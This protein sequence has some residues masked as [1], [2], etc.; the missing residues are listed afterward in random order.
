MP[1]HDNVRSIKFEWAMKQKAFR[2]RTWG[3]TRRG[4]GRNPQG[5]RAG[6]AHRPRE[7]FARRLPVHVT[8]RMARGV[9]NLRSRR[10]FRVIARSL[11]RGGADRFGVRVVQFS[12]QGNHIHWLVEAPD[13]GALARAMKGLA[14]R[15]AKGMNRL[16]DRRGAVIADRFHAQTKK[17]PT[18]VRRA[19]G[20]LRDNARRHAAVRG[21]RLTRRWRDPYAAD[22]RAS[23]EVLGFAL[24]TPV[25]WLVQRAGSG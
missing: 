21:A 11:A 12:V 14:I 8:M 23:I 10:S 17:T 15:I 1:A 7:T 5:E 19:I 18:E 16:M 6:V 20:Y 2:F 3:G 24:P 4:A 22:A 25:T 9:W 13:G